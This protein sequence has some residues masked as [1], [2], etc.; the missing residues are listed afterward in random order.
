ALH[1]TVSQQF[2]CP[3]AI[4]LGAIVRAVVLVVPGGFSA[5]P[6]LL[7]TLR[8]RVRRGG[9]AEPE[10]VESAGEAIRL[11]DVRKAVRAEAIGAQAATEGR[12]ML[13]LEDLS[14]A[15]GG[16]QAVRG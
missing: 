7:A 8:A 3:F 4:I 16:L 5:L 10:Q 13:Q 2:P 11:I 12:T 9:E 15:F 14:K 1:T 6:R